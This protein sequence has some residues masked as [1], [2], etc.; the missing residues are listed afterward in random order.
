MSV[1]LFVCVCVL[2]ERELSN[3]IYQ[4][5]ARAG[6]AITQR[7]VLIIFNSRMDQSGHHRIVLYRRLFHGAP[8]RRPLLSDQTRR[9]VEPRAVHRRV[10]KNTPGIRHH[11]VQRGPS[12]VP[13]RFKRGD[14]P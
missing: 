3:S 11:L 12:I 6:A 5:R 8:R 13:E 9:R 10:D 2:R 1:C 4:R 14:P 7:R